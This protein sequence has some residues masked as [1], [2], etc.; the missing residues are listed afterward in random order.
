MNL[1]DMDL[2]ERL[3]LE[4][5]SHLKGGIYHITQ[6]EMAYNSNKIEGSRL[7][8]KQTAM[9]FE[10]GTVPPL[11]DGT[12]TKL[13]DIKEAENHFKCFDFMLDTVNVPLSEDYFKTV[14]FI[15]K[16]GTSDEKYPLKPIG[17]YKIAPNVIGIG[18]S[19]VETTEPEQVAVEIQALIKRYEAIPLKSFEDIAAFHV[20]FEKIHPF[21]DGNGRAGRLMMFKECLRHNI[22]PF[23]LKD[24]LLS[25]IERLGE[26]RRGELLD[27]LR[28][29][30]DMYQVF[31]DK[32]SVSSIINKR[33][34]PNQ[35][36][37]E[38]SEEIASA[39]FQKKECQIATNE[40]RKIQ[41]YLF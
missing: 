27:T 15:L 34:A 29:E 1:K 25:R 2:I 38:L 31:L 36:N 39:E 35:T 41:N 9:I 28:L 4:K 18:F 37:Q 10:N 32:M 30:Q 33:T 24:I 6:V 23:V 20:A 8:E 21:A 7:S 11:E 13:D 3:R 16:K 14:Q 40:Y 26:A 12:S 22:T 19:E 5:D 17:D